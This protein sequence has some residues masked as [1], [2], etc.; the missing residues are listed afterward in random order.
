MPKYDFDLFTI[1]AGSGGVA[2]SRR[3]GG[4]GAKVAM[5]EESRVGG[6]CVLRGCVPKKLLMYGSM[7]ATAFEDAAGFGWS[8]DNASVDWTRL[9]ARKDEELE[10]LEG[11]YHRMLR[12]AEVEVVDGRGVIV[13]PHT[14]E[15]AGKR[16]TAERILVATGGW[17]KLPKIH[18]IEHVIT[19]NEALDLKELPKRMVIV[20]AGYI[21]VEF[22]G[23]FNAAG[24]DV[25][26]LVRSDGILRGFD[27]DIRGSLRAEMERRGITVSCETAVHSIEKENGELS[28]RL[29]HEEML[30]TDVVMYAT[31]R[32][33]NTRNIGL[34]EV[35]VE[36]GQNGAIVVDDHART[37]VDSIYAIGDVTDRLNL[38]PVAIAEGRALAETWFNMNPMTVSHQ[39]VPTAVFSQ[40]Q[41]GTVGLT[42]EQAR[43]RHEHVD[44]YRVKFRSMKHTLS[45]RGE[46]T[47]MK[48]IV[49]REDDRV[50]GCHMVGEDAAEIVQ[51]L[52]IAL[53]CGATKSQFDATM[54]IHPTAAEEFTTMREPV[55]SEER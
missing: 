18:G 3:A 38:T 49:N 33:P 45:G 55:H 1:G 6:T 39:N 31:G 22:A 48:L 37:S 47:L 30:D 40:P 50:L 25:T 41:V 46:R 35:G 19:S 4:Y 13:D 34:E 11:V 14:V 23:I 15:V 32:A 7:F 36:L 44:I 43:H 16:Y 20:G 10:R 27:Q 54:G 53:Q 29:A 24:V 5:C 42:E 8:V 17:P 21:G 12:D 28:I 51:G 52:G 26:M 2:G 9:V